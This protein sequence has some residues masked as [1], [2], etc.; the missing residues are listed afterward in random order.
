MALQRT[1]PFRRQHDRHDAVRSIL[2]DRDVIEAA[3]RGGH[4]I[5]H[6]DA[7]AK[8]TL[9]DVNRLVRKGVLRDV[10]AVRYAERFMS[11]GK[12]ELDRDRPGGSS[13]S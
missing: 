5:L 4:L 3:K 8:H 10:A 2:R 13:P 11:Y 6:A 7:L 1:Q 12:C 9:L